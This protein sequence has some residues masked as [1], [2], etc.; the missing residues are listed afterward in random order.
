MRKS[1]VHK[2]ASRLT[3]WAAARKR[4]ARSVSINSETGCH[5]WTGSL[6]WS[7]YG[8]VGL[9]GMTWSVHRLAYELANGPIPPFDKCE[10]G[11]YMVLHHCD[12][13]RC[14]NPEHL[15]LGNNADN[16]RDMSSRN[17]G[18]R[19]WRGSSPEREF[20]RTGRVYWEFRGEIRPLMEWSE[21]LGV[22]FTT[23][24]LRF[25]AGWPPEHI[26]APPRSIRR[27]FL[28]PVEYRRFSGDAEAQE[29]RK[30]ATGEG[31]KANTPAAA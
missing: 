21:L 19:G 10:G 23:L 11:R 24:D 9:E 29:A 1:A 17:R 8:Q 25:R 20:A 31:S 5:E 13:P 7:G 16:A 6:T 14:C 26:D 28:E 18:R 30:A 4:I 15:Y 2:S 27:W 12:N 3:D 22:H